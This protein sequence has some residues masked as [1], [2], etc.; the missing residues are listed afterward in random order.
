LL[1]HLPTPGLDVSLLMRRVRADVV[2]A[3]NQKQV[4]WDHSSLMGEVVLMPA[5]AAQTAAPPAVAVERPRQDMAAR[6]DPAS[7]ARPGRP[8][9]ATEN[10]AN[11]T[12]PHGVERYCASSI[13]APQ[14]GNSYGVQHLFS[15]GGTTAWV[16]GKAGQGIGEWVVV[17]FDGPRLVKGIEI[18]NGY[19][20]NSDI[21]YK[22]SRVRRLRVVFSQGESRTFTLQDQLGAQALSLDRPVR[23]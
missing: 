20:K 7:N 10:C 5:A 12:S 3:T 6:T 9:S 4:P 22:N 16:E 2:Q 13:L 15:G 21:Y 1:K 14:L 11:F 17:E 19:Q 8:R 18:H 23:A